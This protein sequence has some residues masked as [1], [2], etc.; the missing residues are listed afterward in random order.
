[1]LNFEKFSQRIRSLVNFDT[2]VKPPSDY[3]E[4]SRFTVVA[5][6]MKQKTVTKNKFLQ[7]NDKRF[8]FPDGILLLPFYHLNLKELN[9]FKQQMGQ[10]IEKYFWD[11]KEKLL[12]IEKSI[13]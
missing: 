10:R 11:E 12:E 5:G 7:I 2:F 13:R 9:E 6:E 1:M 3:K 8:Y 4:V